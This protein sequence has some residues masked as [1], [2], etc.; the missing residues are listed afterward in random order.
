MARS[1]MASLISTLRGMTN[2]GTAD[3]TVGSSTFWSD[4]QLQTILD[5]YVFVVRD[6][7]LDAIQQENTGGTVIYKDYQSRNR[8]FEDTSGGTAQFIIRESAGGSV[9]SS[10]WSANY[11]TGLITFDNDTRGTA[12]SLSGRSYDVYAAAADVWYQKAAHAAE[13]IDFST[14][15]HSIKRSNVYASSIAMA[16]RYESMASSSVNSGIVEVIRGD[17]NVQRFDER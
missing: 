5:R 1:T 8:F 9:V 11:D 2:A 14:A 17:R 4:D 16:K 10:G 3:F 6:E 13:Q 7:Y 15:G 12:Y